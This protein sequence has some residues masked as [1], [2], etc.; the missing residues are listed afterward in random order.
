MTCQDDNEY[1]DKL[2]DFP[3]DDAEN[4]KVDV[5]SCYLLCALPKV[6]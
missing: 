6:Q 3:F 5:S 4:A 2:K 1:N